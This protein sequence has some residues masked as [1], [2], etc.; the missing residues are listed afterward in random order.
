MSLTKIVFTTS[1]VAYYCHT[2]GGSSCV[3]AASH[4][5]ADNSYLG[6]L[7]LWLILLA[8]QMEMQAV[9]WFESEKAQTLLETLRVLRIFWIWKSNFK[10]FWI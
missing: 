5:T 9:D 6:I 3:T 7:L 10:I 2:T 8:T 1:C 4:T